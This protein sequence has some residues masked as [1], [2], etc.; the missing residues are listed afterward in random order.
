MIFTS[1]LPH[2]R[3]FVP[4]VVQ[5]SA[6]DCGPAAL[7]ALLE[8]FG[9]PVSYGRLREAC[10]TDVDGTSIDTLE[11][12]AIQLGLDA[13][14]TMVPED[15]LLLPEAGVL[16]AL[17][18][19]RQPNGLT[20]FVVIWRAHR[21]VAQMMDPAT[22]RIWITHKHLR[23]TLYPHTQQVPNDF[24]REWLTIESFT[25]P[26]RRRLSNLRL[27]AAVIEGLCE[28]ALQDE[29]WHAPAALD[30]AVRMVTAL[31]RAGGLR[32]GDEARRALEHLLQNVRE[33]A[34][35][36]VQAIIPPPYWSVRPAPADPEN[37]LISG[38]VILRIAG[39]LSETEPATEEETAAP[40]RL[41]PELVAALSEHARKPF[42][43]IL[44][45]LRV[46]GSL[47]VLVAL[48]AIM[49][50]ALGVTLEALLLKGLIE[51]VHILPYFLQR[52]TV[53][54]AMFAFLAILFLLE[55]P[56]IAIVKHLGRWLE[57]RLR[58][59]ILQ[60]IPR[61]GD[62]YFHSRLT[63][64]LA[65]R[66]HEI[67][68][69]RDLPTLAMFFARTTS[70]IVLTTAGIIWL[71]PA[72]AALA[73]IASTVII[74]L[75]LL[76]HPW[77][78]ELD[79]RF[80]SHIGALSHFYLDALLGLIPLR[81]HRAE[82]SLQREHESILVKWADAGMAFYWTHFGILGGSAIVS[83]GFAVWLLLN[84]LAQRGEV[85][86]VLLLLYWTLKLP[87]LGQAFA[88][89][90]Q[91]YPMQ[92]NRVLR[93]LEPLSAPEESELW[94]TE[95]HTEERAPEA[96][97][98][99]AETSPTSGVAI[100]MQDVSIQAGGNRI[101]TDIQCVIRSGEHVALVGPSGA[102]KS[103]LVGL[104]LGWHR[105]ATGT[106]RVD[107]ALLHGKRLRRLRKETAWVDP[108][109]QLWNR[110][111]EAN[112]RYGA[113]S[114]ADLNMATVV[115]QADLLDLLA[116]LPEGEQT[117]LGEGGGLVSGGE[118]QRVRLGR[119]MFAEPMRLVILDEPFR[120]LDR[121][122]RRELLIRARQYWQQAT[123]LFI[124]H[125]LSE[126]L[127]FDRVLV[128]ENG[129]ILEDD[130]PETLMQQEDSHFRRLIDSE[131]AM[132][133]RVWENP[134]WRRLWMEEGQL[135]DNG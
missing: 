124:S 94:Y 109:I 123:L 59:A 82:K 114:K 53:L 13:E 11:E 10:Q 32:A 80:R 3:L 54:R 38:A 58:I 96:A 40:R 111:L 70:E 50:A 12:V 25:D 90:A 127:T 15:H 122:K 63:S 106:V 46:D 52:A 43:E 57:I 37:L 92:H 128:I 133:R 117:L 132:R 20:H 21:A 98:E 9:I 99:P 7:K 119:A 78:K 44:R 23:H 8:G 31:V 18:V 51:S 72:S 48:I 19:V 135:R 130:T 41:S 84:Y 35:E 47:P 110:S 76:T 16:P 29:N 79:L 14:Q 115:Q 67:R 68:Q 118:G 36:E 30:A 102:G 6:M 108:A 27:D 42:Q 112:L 88:A 125:D 66:A 89:L 26:L 87:F 103:S 93:L 4:E 75:S 95:Q 107:G 121:N 45:A 61:L 33:A 2:R 24:A 131:N 69:L 100:Q 22:G 17:V 71:N 39:R 86:G 101:L 49:T 91:Q 56:L 74:G 5:T 129:Q 73:I 85:S 116:H 62:R 105:P 55:I 120:G 113:R 64:D 126:A 65:Q 97:A 34:P 28:T 83:T 77:L 60:K 81:T 134:A 104:L 1:S